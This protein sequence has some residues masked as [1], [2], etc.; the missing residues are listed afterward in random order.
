M[1]NLTTDAKAIF[2]DA[3]DCQTDAERVHFLSQAC[4]TEAGLRTRVED[5]LRAHYAAGAFLG[6]QHE[7]TIVEGPG[8][9]VGPYKLMEQI[10]EGGMGLVFVA[11]QQHPVRRKV[12][13]KVIKPGMDTREVVA[14]FEAERQALALMD[15]PNIARVFDAGAT[16]SGRPYFVM[17]LVRGVGITQFC[18]ES[19]LTTN[20]RLEL[21]VHVCQAVQHAHQKGIIHRDLKASNILVTLHDGRP[22]VK[23]IDFGVAKAIG[24]Q[25]TD[26]TIYT[27]FAQMIGTPM[28]MSPE[29]AEMSGLDIDTRSDIYALG[30]LLYELLT[31]TTPFDSD[32]MRVAAFDEMRRIVREE[33]PPRPSTRVSTLG[34]A[35]ATV[36]ANRRSEPKR[37]CQLFRNELDWVVMKAM[38]KDRN[39]RY[40]TASAFAADVRR[41]LNDEPVLACPPTWVYRFGKVARR[42]RKT[43]LAISLVLVALVGGIVGTTWGMFRATTAEAVAWSEAKQKTDALLDKDAALKDSTDRLYQALLNRARAERS[44]GRIGQRFEALKAIREAAKIRITS[45]LR[46]EATAALVLPDAELVQEWE[47]PAE[48]IGSAFDATL[49]R[50]ARSDKQGG[51]A[52]CRLN[53]GREEIITRLDAHGKAPLSGIV[54]TPGALFVACGYGSTSDPADGGVL[55]WQV[56]GA[57]LLSLL[58]EPAG[59]SG[60]RSLAFHPDGTQLAIG[61][62]DQSVDVYDLT[63]RRRVH[64]LAV[65][66]VPVHVAYHP[67]EHRLAVA[68]GKGVQ[69][70]NTNTGKELP[71]LRHP[72]TVTHVSWHP[73]GH[74]LAAGCNDRKIHIWDTQTATEVMAPWT[75]HSAD[76]MLLAFNRTGDQLT[77]VDWGSSP[78]LWD[79]VTG[80]KLLTLPGFGLPFSSNGSLLGPG[81]RADKIGL[82]RLASGHE[83]RVLRPRNAGSLGNIVHPV[84]HADGRTLA[85][86]SH[87]ELCFFDLMSGEELAAA[88]LTVADTANPTYFDPAHPKFGLPKVRAEGW[89]TGGHHGLYLWPTRSDPMRPE[90]LHVG[91]PQQIAPQSSGGFSVGAS[92]STDGRIVAVPQGDS[93][94]VLDRDRPTWH[95]ELGLQDNVRFS[96]VSPDGRFIVTCSWESDV[97]SKTIRVWD[98][99]TGQPICDLATDG[100]ASAAFSPDG[101][102]LMTRTGIGCTQWEVGSWKEMRRFGF[103][104]FVFSPDS[105]L[106]AINDLFSVIRLLDTTTGEEVA[107]LTGPEPTWYAPACF[108][109]D[110]TKLVATCSGDT[111]LYVWDLRAIRQQLKELDLDWDWPDFPPAISSKPRQIEVLLGDLGKPRPTLTPEQKARRAIEKYR[112]A[113]EAEPENV[114]ACN[115]LAWVYA[116]GVESVRDVKAALP[117]AEKAVRSAPTNAVFRNTLGVIYY[118]TG[119]YREAVTLLRANLDSNQDWA[120]ACDLY[121]LAM[122]HQQ[123]GES[124]KAKE[125]YDWAIRWPRS[126][127]RYTA[128][129]L[130]ELARFRDEASERLG[131]NSEKKK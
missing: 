7:T 86:S 124:A 76:G 61:H 42:Y 121:F 131:V 119:R 45:E 102:F 4:G 82:W 11:E 89:V 98:A 65:A 14:R 92:A 39:R 112:A 32:R 13:V 100:I 27:R 60:E 110:G 8:T 18:D 9:A 35:T 115:N 69:L 81:S 64:R 118:R 73:D 33:Q 96:A 104:H 40:E 111:A 37:L 109:P 28:Y 122:S 123:L 63:T 48:S 1:G 44:S 58:P 41:Y 46:T 116:T 99:A 26:K 38:E 49:L 70:F 16:E 3:L 25:L 114:L 129:Y 55:V 67:E 34:E 94:L 74:R 93:T 24:Q 31:G 72:A 77:S 128:D 2:L 75:G 85:A 53:R 10:G 5:L 91:P 56:D 59:V 130:E 80:R 6:G 95:L 79:A 126:D 105:R 43:V 20:E 52:V 68:C 21:F 30:V 117:L 87:H 12:A 83:L 107:K 78:R 19:R 97:H 113:V 22:V 120:L 62:S 54:V 90:V 66:A 103:G 47:R 51:V 15:H 71:A 17:E 106:L 50:Y 29:Q 127:P 108:T 57:E 23:V 125:Y 36:S 84:V 101:R 88:R